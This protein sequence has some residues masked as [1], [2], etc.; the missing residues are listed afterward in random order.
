MECRKA[1][2][3][4]LACCYGLF[5]VNREDLI[6]GRH[7]HF[8]IVP[9]QVEGVVVLELDL[10]ASVRLSHKEAGGSYQVVWVCASCPCLRL[11]AFD[12]DVRC[13]SAVTDHMQACAIVSEAHKV[14][15]VVG[16][17]QKVLA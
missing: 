8:Q 15:Y 11:G 2:H 10:T 16:I 14:R 9:R 6:F 4:G 12:A 3:F 17:D 13:A 7:L 1:C 5:P